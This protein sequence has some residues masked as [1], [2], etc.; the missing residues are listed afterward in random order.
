MN[1][2]DY[3]SWQ[4]IALLFISLGVMALSFIALIHGA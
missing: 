1:K 2:N 4:E 3:L